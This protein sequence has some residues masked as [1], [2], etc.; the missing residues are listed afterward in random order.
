MGFF[1]SKI[2]L[3]LILKHLESKIPN[4]LQL[5]TSHYILICSLFLFKFWCTHSYT[6]FILE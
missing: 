2:E 4:Q 5:S 6:S 1:E 3:Y